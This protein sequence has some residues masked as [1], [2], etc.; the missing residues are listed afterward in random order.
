M[1][2]KGSAART[3]EGCLPDAVY[4]YRGYLAASTGRVYCAQPQSAPRPVDPRLQA[5]DEHFHVAATWEGLLGILDEDPLADRQSPPRAVRDMRLNDLFRLDP[6]PPALALADAC[7]F[8][9]VQFEDR[10][11]CLEQS[12]GPVDVQWDDTTGIFAARTLDEARAYCQSRGTSPVESPRA[13]RA[14]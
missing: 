7:G 5:G 13:A 10:F 2:A 8:N 3:T 14:A 4:A 6:T 9:V 1:S 11:Y 12:R